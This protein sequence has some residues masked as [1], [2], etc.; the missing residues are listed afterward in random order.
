MNRK[1]RTALIA[2]FVIVAIAAA[3]SLAFLAAAQWWPAASNAHIRW[4]GHSA[5]LSGVFESGAFQF[6]VA[7]AAITLAILITVAALLFAFTISAIALGTVA[8]FLALP[9]IVIAAC[10]WWAVRRNRR[11]ALLPGPTPSAQV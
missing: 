9:L 6:M 8:L 11:H 1:L 2:S 10:I 5:P 4:G 3:L 7:W